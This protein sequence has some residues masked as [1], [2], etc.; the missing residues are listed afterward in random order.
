M[1]LLKLF[2]LLCITTVASAQPKL[3]GTTKKAWSGVDTN[4]IRAHVVY[5]ADDKLLGRLPGTPGY[6]M[7]VDYVVGEFK[8]MGVKPGGENGSYLQ[9][10][11]LRKSSIQP[12]SV[13]MTLGDQQGN[14]DSINRTDIMI[15]AH[16]FKSS[17]QITD[18]PLVF[19]GFGVDLPGIHNDY[20]NMDVKGK[21]VV[22]LNE[23]P[24]G[25]SSVY[26]THFNGIGYKMKVAKEK[27][28]I[29]I[30]TASA[31]NMRVYNTG[32]NPVAP[33]PV[34]PLT[35]AINSDN[36]VA[37][38]TR[39]TGQLDL[40]ISTSNNFLRELFLN[41]GKKFDDVVAALR[42]GKQQ[43]F[44]LPKKLSVSYTSTY[45]DV[46]TYNVIGMI[47]GTDAVLKNEYVVHTAHL[48]HVGV[49]RP[50]NGDSIYNGAHDNASGV[51]SLLEIARIYINGNAK[52][53]R[54]VLIT[55]VAAEESGLIGSS[56]FA[57]NP[58]VPRDKIVAN[59]NTDMPTVI[60]PLLSIVPLGA[61]H[62]TMMKHVQ[63][64]ASTL[65]LTIE[66][67]RE[68]NEN[69]FIRSDQY[70]FV[71]EHIPAVNCKYGA[72]SDI[73]GFDLDKYVKEWRAK[74]YH[75]PQD[76]IEGGIFN[77]TAAKT[78]VQLNFLISYSVAMDKERP[79]WNEGELF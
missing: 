62:S 39:Y 79:K 27:G 6:Q 55:M 69:F 66:E 77:F 71:R 64:A 51:A 11:T 37:Y 32:G 22:I 42:T 30:I 78:Y 28:A 68:P 53:K 70:S 58:T 4:Q 36:T 26:S 76:Q 43:S 8:K 54:S 35:T 75:K 49:G 57:S 20:A 56:Y 21:I 3:G 50:V 63:F 33:F 17:I 1:K 46:E 16:P 18:A 13:R 41:S 2:I 45:T 73:P 31:N 67:D 24:K 9:K 12:T 40:Y 72:K 38:G 29:G 23:A 44:E 52:P 47:P 10:F 65:G 60:A 59:V 15:A 34:V 5:L 7:A 48:D 19:A 74:Y 61:L 14:I 25:M